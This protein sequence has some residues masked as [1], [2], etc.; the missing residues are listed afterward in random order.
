MQ[1]RARGP[2]AAAEQ[3][4]GTLAL[5]L[6]LTLTLS[7]RNPNPTKVAKLF[8]QHS[9][10]HVLAL[11]LM[12]TEAERQLVVRALSMVALHTHPGLPPGEAARELMQPQLQ[13]SIALYF[14]E[15]PSG[16]EAHSAGLNPLIAGAAEQLVAPVDVYV[17]PPQRI[18][19]HSEEEELQQASQRRGGQPGHGEEMEMSTAAVQNGTLAPGHTGRAP[20]H[21]GRAPSATVDV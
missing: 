7:P 20:G 14:D 6:T 18:L 16:A 9:W 17:G 4:G 2:R 10:G 13:R 3:G 1:P 11:L 15:P 5:A 19:L 21:T 12:C 8:K